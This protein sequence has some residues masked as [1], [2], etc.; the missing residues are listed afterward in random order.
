MGPEFESSDL[1][2]MLAVDHWSDGKHVTHERDVGLADRDVVTI[3][4]RTWIRK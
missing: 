3:L 4:A 2:T 1:L